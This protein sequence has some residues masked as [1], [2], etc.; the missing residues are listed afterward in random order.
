MQKQILQ[1]CSNFDQFCWNFLFAIYKTVYFQS[2]SHDACVFADIKT[3][4]FLSIVIDCVLRK[5]ANDN[6][7]DDIMTEMVEMMEMM[8]M[9]EMMEMME[10]R[11]MMGT[12]EFKPFEASEHQTL[13]KYATLHW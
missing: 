9:M 7:K 12:Q 4:I 2:T 3:K 5:D 11:K 6:E 8:G 1:I 13:S 10:M